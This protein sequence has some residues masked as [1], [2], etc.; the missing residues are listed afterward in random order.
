MGFF[1]CETLALG[2]MAGKRGYVI[3]PTGSLAAE[4]HIPGLISLFNEEPGPALYKYFATEKKFS[5]A[6]GSEIYVKSAEAPERIV[7]ADYAWAWLDEPGT[8][9]RET[10]RRLMGRMRGCDCPLIILT[11][12]PEGMNWVYEEVALPAER[13]EKGFYAVY[14]TSRDN[15]KNL[16]ANYFNFLKNLPPSL[17]AAWVEGKFVNMNGLPAY[18]CFNE[19]NHLRGKIAFGQK[20]ET[21]LCVDF[22]VNPMR[23][24][25][26]QET[27]EG[28]VIPDDCSINLSNSNTYEAAEAA[29]SK[30]AKFGFNGAVKIYGDASGHARGTNSHETDYAIIQRIVP[31]AKIVAGRRNPSVRDRVNSVNAAFAEKKLFIS[32]SG[33]DALI[34][35]LRMV[36]FS[37]GSGETIDKKSDLDL[38]HAS[39][40]L[41]YYVYARGE[42]FRR[43]VAS[44]KY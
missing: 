21:S 30:L 18:G 24:L 5:F 7:G 20:L 14:G 44:R 1:F 2:C 31:N 33:N 22:N 23:W 13:G 3:V 6:N 4:I 40:A 34:R 16:P 42:A 32:R 43:P 9:K 41:G 10:W 19:S 8:M 36:C 39:D 26:A 11:G 28:T 15:Q 37:D 25:I 12:T 27:E 17:A 35:D 38:T 29:S